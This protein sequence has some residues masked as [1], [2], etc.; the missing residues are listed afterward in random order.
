M[1]VTGVGRAQVGPARRFVT[2][3]QK[4]K[5]GGS[6]EKIPHASQDINTPFWKM[7]AEQFDSDLL[8]QAYLNKFEA[9]LG[10][11]MGYGVYSISRS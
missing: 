4:K 5:G 8:R 7:W 10:L 6:F 11:R 1:L 3:A 2:R 9:T